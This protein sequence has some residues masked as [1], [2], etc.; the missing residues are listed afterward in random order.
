MVMEGYFLL[1]KLSLTEEKSFGLDTSSVAKEFVPLVLLPAKNF[2]LKRIDSNSTMASVAS[3]PLSPKTS[4][5]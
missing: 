5:H 2:D 1:K 4:S 3:R